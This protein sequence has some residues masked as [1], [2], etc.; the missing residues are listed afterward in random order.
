MNLIEKL[1]EFEPFRTGHRGL[2]VE[3]SLDSAM[4]IRTELHGYE[5]VGEELQYFFRTKQRWMPLR[6]LEAPD[7]RFNV[8]ERLTVIPAIKHSPDLLHIKNAFCSLGIG[9]LGYRSGTRRVV[10]P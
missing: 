8:G 2:G 7:L 9:S 1:E 10:R 6:A 4:Q 5:I 3:L